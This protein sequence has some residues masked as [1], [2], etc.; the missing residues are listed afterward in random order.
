MREEGQTPGSAQLWHHPGCSCGTVVR[1]SA[2][3]LMPAVE[4]G[5]SEF[6]LKTPGQEDRKRILVIFI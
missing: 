3:A 1:I 5:V 4:C 2:L 6:H